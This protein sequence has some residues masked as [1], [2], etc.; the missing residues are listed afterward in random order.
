MVF[1]VALDYIGL[2]GKVWRKILITLAFL[3]IALTSIAAAFNG[4]SGLQRHSYHALRFSRMD[5]ELKD[6]KASLCRATTIAQLEDQ[7]RVVRRMMLGETTDWYEGM[8]QQL[9]ESPT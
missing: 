3:S 6:V 8:E 2:A 4:Y 9:I 7:L 5:K 1:H